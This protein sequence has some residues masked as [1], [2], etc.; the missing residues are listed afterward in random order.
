VEQHSRVEMEKGRFQKN[1]LKIRIK[2]RSS[3][4]KG[5]SDIKQK[6]RTAMRQ[7]KRERPRA[8][9]VRQHYSTETREEDLKCRYMISIEVKIEG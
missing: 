9:W 8:G 5:K 1:R 6:L 7:R 2:E 4:Y 3:D